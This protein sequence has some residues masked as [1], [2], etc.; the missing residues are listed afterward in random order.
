MKKVLFMFVA[1]TFVLTSCS[2][3]NKHRFNQRVYDKGGKAYVVLGAENNAGHA[4]IIVNNYFIFS[5][6]RGESYS[7]YIANGETFSF[8]LSPGNYQLVKYTLYGEVSYFG[9]ENSIR[10]DFTKYTEGSFSLKEGD[11]VYLGSIILEIEEKAKNVWKR[12][13][14]FAINPADTAYTTSV[15]NKLSSVDIEA[16]ETEAGKNIE[17][18]LMEW[19]KK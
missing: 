16:F 2:S 15:Q 11:A 10:A 7:L 19:K 17:V 8:L 14:G 12:F 4:D 13:F 5:N 9:V 6:D 3:L 18:R 1:L